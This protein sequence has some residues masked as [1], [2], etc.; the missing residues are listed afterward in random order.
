MDLLAPPFDMFRD[1]IVV[2]G[3]Q[4]RKMDPGCQGSELNRKMRDWK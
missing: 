4:T 2:K 1:E 3:S